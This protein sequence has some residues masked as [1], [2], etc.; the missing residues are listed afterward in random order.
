[1]I[2]FPVVN[3]D[4]S[5]TLYGT[6]RN[7]SELRD[8]ILTGGSMNKSIDRVNNQ[9]S[10]TNNNQ[11]SLITATSNILSTTTKSE[12]ICYLDV[13]VRDSVRDS[14]KSSSQDGSSDGS[15]V[16]EDQTTLTLVYSFDW[17]IVGGGNGR[18]KDKLFNN[19][20]TEANFGTGNL[21]SS[22]ANAVIALDHFAAAAAAAVGGPKAS[23]LSTINQRKLSNGCSSINGGDGALCSNSDDHHQTINNNNR[24]HSSFSLKNN[25][26]SINNNNNDND[27]YDILTSTF[28]SFSSF[29][30][31]LKSTTNSKTFLI[32]ASII[33][34]TNLISKFVIFV[35]S[36]DSFLLFFINPFFYLSFTSCNDILVD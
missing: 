33:I 22:N 21:N 6:R 17:N 7:E 2:F 31:W 35:L 3:I 5:G 1:M 9:M 19:N 25:S 23:D 8:Y 32:Y 34:F 14:I 4:G 29:K 26:K 11:S 28:H 20:G 10:M 24:P 12:T 30:Q 27:N 18:G 16:Y 15:L 13:V 36:I